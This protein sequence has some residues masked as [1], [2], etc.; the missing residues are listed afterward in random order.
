MKLKIKLKPHHIF[1]ISATIYFILNLV[2]N[3]LHYTLGRSHNKKFEFTYPSFNEW[4]QIFIIMII[5]SFL[6]GW[7]TDFFYDY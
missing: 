6:Q 1:I 3:Y 7:F 4:I 2:E 5:F